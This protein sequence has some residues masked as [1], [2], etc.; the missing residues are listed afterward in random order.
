MST[1]RVVGSGLVCATTAGLGAVV[2]VLVGE[3]H[4]G[5]AAGA[6]VGGTVGALAGFFGM[7]ALNHDHQPAPQISTGVRF[8]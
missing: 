4:G 5:T 8:P 1:L 7:N 2:G 3:K 6:I